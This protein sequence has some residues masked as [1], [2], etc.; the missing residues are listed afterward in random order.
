MP[1]DAGADGE[2]LAHARTDARSH[3]RA[4]AH[5]DGRSQSSA[6]AGANDVRAVVCSVAGAQCRAHERSDARAVV[7]P[8]AGA[9]CRALERA[10]TRTDCSSDARTDAR[11]RAVNKTRSRRRGEQNPVA[12]TRTQIFS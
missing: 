1:S 12:P 4:D 6:F 9:Q 3:G 5:A 2:L 11:P 8:V 10:D 7:R